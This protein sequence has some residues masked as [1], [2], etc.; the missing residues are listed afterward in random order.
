MK[1]A[2]YLDEYGDYLETNRGAKTMYEN[3]REQQISRKIIQRDFAP[4]F[5]VNR[6][7]HSRAKLFRRLRLVLFGVVCGLLGYLSGYV[8]FPS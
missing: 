2:L 8:I 4:L 7:A 6:R 5:A 1:A 3:S